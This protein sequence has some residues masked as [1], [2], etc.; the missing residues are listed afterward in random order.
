MNSKDFLDPTEFAEVIRNAPLVSIDLIVRDKSGRV[1]LGKRKNSPAKRFWFVPGGR[2]YKGEELMTAR[3]RVIKEELGLEAD[4]QEVVFLGV[5]D[6]IYTD[7]VFE[8]PSYGTHF[9]VLAHQ[10]TLSTVP[11]S[12]PMDEHE[13]YKWWSTDQLKLSREVHPFTKAYF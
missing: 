6:H 11:V 3:R 4:H 5:F 9:V 12:L 8:D 13:G 10:L 2:I 1:L 7:N